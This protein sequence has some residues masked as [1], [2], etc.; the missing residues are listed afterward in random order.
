MV[1]PVRLRSLRQ[2][3]G[4]QKKL[5]L[6]IF[7]FTF[8]WKSVKIFVCLPAGKR[9]PPAGEGL[10]ENRTFS[11]QKIKRHFR[12]HVCK[13]PRGKDLEPAGHVKYQ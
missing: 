11:Y 4:D 7:L 5:F 1:R 10:A 13:P 6:V 8:V 2:A 3:Q 12:L 9:K